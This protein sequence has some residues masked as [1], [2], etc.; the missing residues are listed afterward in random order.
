MNRQRLPQPTPDPE[1]QAR[2][3]KGLNDLVA[4]LKRGIGP[5]TAG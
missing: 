4:Q 1:M 5:S 3:S 2:V